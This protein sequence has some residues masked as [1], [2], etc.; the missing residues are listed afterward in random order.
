M[1]KVFV[2]RP[3]N[4]PQGLDVAND[5]G[6]A[7]DIDARSRS[8]RTGDVLYGQTGYA[9]LQHSR[10]VGNTFEFDVVH[11]YRRG[12]TG[13]HPATDVLITRYHHFFYLSAV[14]FQDNIHWAATD[15]HLLGKHTNIA[16]LQ[17]LSCCGFDGEASVY[18]GNGFCLRFQHLNKSAHEC[19]T[20]LTLYRSRN[21][22]GCLRR[23]SEDGGEQQ[24]GKGEYLLDFRKSIHYFFL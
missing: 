5:G 6:P 22:A 16:G 9:S 23:Y 8:E 18:V 14:Y 15:F 2:H 10:H 12:S 11:F 21:G 20:L 13:V 7:A 1:Y 17:G 24:Q 3:V 19:F 4:H